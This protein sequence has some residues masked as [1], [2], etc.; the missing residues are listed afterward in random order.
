ML[1]DLHG[2]ES[3][4]TLD[5]SYNMITSISSDSLASTPNLRKL[6]ISHNYVESVTSIIS[7]SLITLDLSYNNLVTNPSVPVSLTYLDLSH[8]NISHVSFVEKSHLQHLDLSFNPVHQLS[9]SAFSGKQMCVVLFCF[10][11]KYI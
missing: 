10:H 9:S 4:I 5:M 3:L 1:P 8:N 7:P 11:W 2:L 6:N